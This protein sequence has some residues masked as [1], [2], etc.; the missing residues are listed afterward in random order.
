[1]SHKRIAI[2][3]L[4][5]GALSLAPATGAD[6]HSE[7]PDPTAL[8]DGVSEY[9]TTGADMVG[10]AVTAHFSAAPSETQIWAATGVDSGGVFGAQQD[11][12]LTQNGDTFGNPWTLSYTNAGKGLLT[13]FS[14]DGFAAG[15]KEIGVMFDRTFDDQFGTPGSFK[16]WD[17]T[18]VTAGVPFDTLINFASAV[19]IVGNDPVGDEFRYLN[20]RFLNLGDRDEFGNIPPTVS[21]LDGDVIRSLQFIQDTN[22]PIVVPEPTVL[23]I[24]S[25][26]AIGMLRR[27]R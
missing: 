10:M 17:Y 6:Y 26:G 23:L 9:K 16:G 7:T 20:V 11:W 5:I 2:L 13:G 27:K 4:A 15:P 1:M 12:S 18:T 19:A 24:L 21:G 25:A 3:V 22:N 8:I 14:I